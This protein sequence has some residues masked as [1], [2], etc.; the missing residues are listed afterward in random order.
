MHTQTLSFTQLVEAKP[1]EVYR[2]FTN[3]T[4]L[5][6]WLCDVATVI[7]HAGGRLYLWWNSGY[8][9]SGEFLEAESDKKLVFTWLGRGEPG[10]S[11]VQV[12]FSEQDGGTQVT[13]EH[14]GLGIGEDWSRTLGAVESGWKRG[15]ENLASVLATGE[16]LRFTKRPML[17][18]LIGEF[19][20]EIAK[21]LG[22][23]VA[24]A[25]RLDGV[26]DNMGAKAAGLQ[27][28]DVIVRMAGIP[29]V[30]WDSLTFA[31]QKHRAGDKVEI[32]FYRGKE[33]KT[34]MMELSHRPIPDITFSTQELATRVRKIYAEMY[35]EI[36]KFL[37]GVTEEEGSFKP[38]PDEWSIK[39][40]LAHMIHGERGYQSWI[41][42]LIGGYE[43]V[44]DDYGG[45]I[46]AYID[47]TLAVYPSIPDLVS[48]YKRAS[49][50]TVELLARLPEDFLGRKSGYWRVAYASLEEPY[51]FH[52]HIDQMRAAL[53]AARAAVMAT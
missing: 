45:N 50:E 52:G 29:T 23:P 25:V 24:N 42:D 33:K 10:S 39:G 16:D 48:A 41:T 5:R 35:A 30:D 27:A 8:Y 6:E 20:P 51:H 36:E 2:A 19:N 40:N 13:L 26:V 46:H 14:S 28:N 15:L 17:G 18:I 1:S 22:V 4:A 44:A 43:R 37:A 11:Q 49:S 47:A 12:T 7:P 53:E 3:A 9:A 34:A 31:L 38:D 21:E 32:I